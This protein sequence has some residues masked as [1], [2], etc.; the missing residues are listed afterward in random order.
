MTVQEQIQQFEIMLQTTSAKYNDLEKPDT[1]T[2]LL[3]LNAA[4]LKYL[5]EKY[6]GLNELKDN[7]TF[8]GKKTEEFRALIKSSIVAS[9]VM[10][11]YYANYGKVF[12]LPTDYLFYLKSDSKVTRVT[13]KP[14]T[15]IYIPN[16]EV[17]YHGLDKL[18]TTPFNI[19]VILK[20]GVFFRE[21]NA[22]AGMLVVID[23]Y[24]TL[25]E[26]TITYLRTPKKLVLT[27]VDSATETDT[28][29][30]APYVHYEIMVLALKMFEEYKYRLM[31]SSTQN[32]NTE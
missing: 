17:E 15:G 11:D 4:Q 23:K 27:V 28:C 10:T 22:G 30:F 12:S 19:P 5:K 24:T 9:N 1:D 13:V 21:Y 29:E 25:T 14:C 31:Q 3:Y 32:K 18:M 6:I 26:V 2:M 7:V 20:P 16:V 8:I